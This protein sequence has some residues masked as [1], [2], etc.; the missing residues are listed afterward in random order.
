MVSRRAKYFVIVVVVAFAFA[1][2]MGLSG[3]LEMD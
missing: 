3:L 1:S 2:L